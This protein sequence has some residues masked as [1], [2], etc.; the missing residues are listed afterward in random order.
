MIPKLDA[1]LF[2]CSIV[3]LVSLARCT[4]EAT[5]PPSNASNATSSASTSQV[6]SAGQSP[7]C[8]ASHIMVGL[9]PWTRATNL[10][11][12]E[13]MRFV[14]G[15]PTVSNSSNS[16]GLGSHA[17]KIDTGPYAGRIL[18]FPSSNFN[19]SANT[20]IYDPQSNSMIAGQ[21]LPSAAKLS[22]G[23]HS[24]KINS[25]PNSGKT[26]V[27][28]GRNSATTALYNPTTNTFSTGPNLSGLAQNGAHSFAIDSG[29][30]A[31]SVIIV[32]GNTLTSSTVYDPVAGTMVAGPV[33]S[34]S[35]GV[36][37]HAV[38][39]TTGPNTGKVLVVHGG[40]SATTS[41]FDPAT[42]A[43]SIGKSLKAAAGDGAHAI[44]INSG[45]NSG[46]V[47]F[48]HGNSSVTTS[49]YNPVTDTMS[50]GSSLPSNVCDGGHAIVLTA[51]PEIGKTLVVH[52]CGKSF[53]SIYDP[54]TNSYSAGPETNFVLSNSTH[55]FTPT[56][57]PNTGKTLLV[58]ASG[59]T[60][61]ALFDPWLNTF[62]AGPN[63]SAAADYG[64]LSFLIS[65]GAH[66]GKTLV[67]HAGSN[68]KTSLY[69][70]GLNNFSVGPN[71]TCNAGSGANGFA[72]KE[73]SKAGQ[74]LIVCGDNQSLTTLYDPVAHTFY[75]GP[76][77]FGSATAQDG[78][79][80]FAPN[81]GVYA[82]KTVVFHSGGAT[83]SSAY[84]PATNSFSSAGPNLPSASVSG[85]MTFWINS[86]PNAGK[87]L[88][89]PGNG[90]STA[91]TALF[92]PATG[93]YS[94]AGQF[95]S[96]NWDAV[97]GGANWFN[98]TSG[99][100]VGKILVVPGCNYD[101]AGLFDP[102]ITDFVNT[103]VPFPTE[104]VSSGS[105]VFPILFGPNVGKWVVML[106]N[107][108]SRTN[109]Y[110]PTTGTFSDF[111]AVG[112]AGGSAPA[113]SAFSLAY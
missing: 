97:C 18:I 110:D 8:K 69:D 56:W 78:S 84:D 20:S 7:N 85:S 17:F 105:T 92:D 4:T 58:A 108:S 88:T 113:N 50:N 10:F 106:G 46:R 91:F 76:T 47:L 70:P 36:G 95:R 32:H 39:L 59:R 53:T 29:S 94:A 98:I 34:A 6:A 16:T 51:G 24:F 90:G 101:G 86:G 102:N 35:V 42:T 93:L 44:A 1:K 66:S 68:N 26:L 21:P 22:A 100:N 33:L 49:L 55:T 30:G 89:I 99:P 40:Y 23:G 45:P 80:N 25:G 107:G 67:V 48:V 54:V 13:S 79:H 111:V 5:L 83:T 73:G 112:G 104:R 57:G 27:I 41:I 75:A 109:L 37:A 15:P 19:G 12:Q 31:G 43:F 64:S 77:L 71:L 52:G 65:N 87:A 61:T 63:L 9:G 81:S 28:L 103:F 38:A 72:V 11:C 96:S 2:L 82:G 60:A 74:T 3:L 62:T 14:A